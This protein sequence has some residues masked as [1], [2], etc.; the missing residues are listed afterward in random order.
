[1]DMTPRRVWPDE[2]FD[3]ADPWRDIDP[4]ER[5]RWRLY[6]FDVARRS[7]RRGGWDLGLQWTSLRTPYG[8]RWR[9]QL[10]LIWCS[11]Q[12]GRCPML[13]Y[14]LHLRQLGPYRNA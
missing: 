4:E 2:V 12:F 6:S 1:M 3:P 7:P 8:T 10:H 9:I 13:A 5:A 14:C 11:L